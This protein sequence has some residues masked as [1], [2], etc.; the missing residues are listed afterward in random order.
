MTVSPPA[1]GSPPGAAPPDR[2]ALAQVLGVSREAVD[3]AQDCDLID[4]HIDLLI[5][6]RLWGYDPLVRHA[7]PLGGRFFFGH[8]DLPRMRD[9]G[10]SGAMWS[11][12]TNPMKPAGLRW[13]TLQ[14]N[15]G[16]LH[17]LV[18]RSA[19]GL[20]FAR[21]AEEYRAAVARGAHAVLWSI[22]GGNALEAA[23]GGLEALPV[24]LLTRVT[25]V[26]LTSSCYGAT[27]T[28]QSQLQ[29]DPGLTA[30]GHALVQQLDAHRVFVDLAHIHPASFWDA[31]AAHDPTLPLIDTHTGVDGANPHWR[32]LDDDQIKAI[33]DTGGVIGIIWSPHF[34]Q[35]KGGP[36][37]GRMV[38]EHMEHVISVV[39][40]DHV[41][42]GTDY[43]GAIVPP[44][45][46]ASGDTFPRVV[47]YMLDAGWSE[48][49]IEKVLGANFL[50]CW[51]HLRPPSS[52]APWRQ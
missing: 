52:Q 20:A 29:R 25:L 36:T 44:K 34:L 8:Q 1:E 19:G 50:R 18:E 4:L 2:E 14:R 37:D 33:A 13:R 38:I 11:I 41:A 5:P 43:D 46:L 26:H 24:G 15:L 7:R 16:N 40:E 23:P 39:G 47:Q 42:I 12:T 35:R 21:D 48:A 51:E 49:R 22:Q 9:G 27:S 45:D 30:A 3:L 32:N 31:V 10:V 6:P 28:P 17:A